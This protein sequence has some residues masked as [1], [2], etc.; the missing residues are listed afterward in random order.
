MAQTNQVPG[1][2]ASAGT[3][4]H[5]ERHFFELLSAFDIA[6]LVTRARA[7][8]ELH[9]RPMAVADVEQDGTL[10]FITNV[11]STKVLEIRD[12][13]RALVSLQSSQQ[14]VSMNGHV[15]LVADRAKVDQIWKEAYRA[16]FDG[17]SDPELV[18]L[19]FRPL[20]AEYWDN[21]A[22][23]VKHAFDGAA[24]RPRGQASNRPDDD[25]QARTRMVL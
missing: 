25:A 21:G 16:W 6:T 1:N 7:T 9:G 12:D 24:A 22:H 5:S 11:D 10:W 2:Y 3:V 20:D 13:S 23:S 4:P 19:R 17:Q 18:L 8:G 14:F 15:E